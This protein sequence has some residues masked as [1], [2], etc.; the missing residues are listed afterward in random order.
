MNSSA[1]SSLL[2]DSLGISGRKLNSQ[3]PELWQ[4][5]VIIIFVWGE[6]SYRYS[7][8]HNDL[9][10]R[11]LFCLNIEL[12]FCCQWDSCTKT[13]KLRRRNCTEWYYHTFMM[14]VTK[15]SNQ[16]FCVWSVLSRY[17]VPS[18]YLHTFDGIIRRNGRCWYTRTSWVNIDIE[19]IEY[20]SKK[21]IIEKQYIK[22]LCVNA[23]VDCIYHSSWSQSKIYSSIMYLFSTPYWSHWITYLWERAC[24]CSLGM[25]AMIMM[26]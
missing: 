20:L 10:A 4:R 22:L 19:E 1:I 6:N 23:A 7:S 21:R 3:I 14:W 16:S 11:F 26:F 2:V 9:L 12:E 25:T 8:S 17:A 15:N 13:W 24:W 5:D 18:F